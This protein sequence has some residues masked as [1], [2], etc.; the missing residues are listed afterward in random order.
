VD[1]YLVPKPEQVQNSGTE[2]PFHLCLPLE[3]DC[4]ASNHL[5][6]IFFW[7]IYPIIGTWKFLIDSTPY[8]A[9]IDE[10]RVR[11][12]ARIAGVECPV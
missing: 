5:F 3:L 6:I 8:T 2:E 9:A 4:G 10:R 11:L 12:G 7:I 1:G